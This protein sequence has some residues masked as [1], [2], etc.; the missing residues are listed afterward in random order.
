M[1]IWS[2][3]VLLQELRRRMRGNR[4]MIILTIYLVLIS[5]IT[6]LIYLAFYSSS[7]ASPDIEDG[8]TIGKAVFITV[9]VTAMIQVCIITPSLTAGTVAGEKERQT[10]DLLITTLLS[11]WEIVLGKLVSALA[12][13][14]LLVLSV[15]P[16]AGVAF[17][18]GGVSGTELVL[19]I[20][21]LLV[22]VLFCAAVGMFWS[23][24]AGTT[25]AATVR[26]QASIILLLLIVPFLFVVAAIAQLDRW[27]FMENLFNIPIFV[28]AAGAVVCFHPFI[29]F[30][31]T[32]AALSEGKEPFFF[33]IDPGRGD[34]L[35]PSPWLAYT[36]LALVVTAVLLAISVRLLKPVQYGTTRRNR[37]Q[38]N[39]AV[40]G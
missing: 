40:V 33:T 31:L 6:L 2:N 30:A 22:T 19:A 9:I 23:V 36:F 15:L 5:L 27:D 32:E 29:A 14:T 7:G 25:L 28:Y 13:A 10:Y 18:F 24:V 38:K 21:M 26:A 3:P 8:R 11:P 37:P 20:I 12:Y 4:A 35:V 17:L 34:I 39:R 16:L 1:N